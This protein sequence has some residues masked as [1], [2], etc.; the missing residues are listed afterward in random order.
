[1]R[2]LI[3]GIGG[4]AG[5]HLADWLI[6]QGEEV[7]GLVRDAQRIEN[8]YHL[9]GKVEIRSCDLR[10]PDAIEAVL[11]E[12]RPQ[13]IYHLAALSFVPSAS[14]SFTETFEI[15]AL[16][17]NHLLDAAH[18]ACPDSRLLYVGSS[19]EYGLGKKTAFVETDALKPQSLYGVSKAAGELLAQAFHKNHGLDVVRARPFNHI[20]PRQD[21]RFVCSSFAR[22]IADIIRKE[23][24]AVIQTGNL[25]AYRDFTDVR[26]VVRAYHL[27]MQKGRTGEGYN[28]CSEK[29]N[30]ISDILDQLVATSGRSIRIETDPARFR[31]E[32]QLPVQGNASRLRKL[33]HWSPK[34]PLDQTLADTL[35]YWESRDSQAEHSRGR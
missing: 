27:I 32:N 10:N 33:T 1:M 25:Q 4:F 23:K 5:S 8:I 34:I 15:N 26:D 19:E 20:G 2:N 16:A 9:R 24:P 13:R 3:T 22:Q 28:I 29:L 35:A 30:R 21:P 31:Q 17:T 12:L 6:S 11:A 18:K 7:I 14:D